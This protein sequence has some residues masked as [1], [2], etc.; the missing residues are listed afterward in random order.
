MGDTTRMI[1]FSS[2]YTWIWSRVY[3]ISFPG[4]QT[5]GLSMKL[6]IW[7][8]WVFGLLAAWTSQ[9]Q[10]SHELAPHR[11]S[12][13]LFFYLCLTPLCPTNC[14]LG[15]LSHSKLSFCPWKKNP[16]FSF[17]KFPS[18]LV[19]LP[20]ER[21]VSQLPAAACCYLLLPAATCCYLLL[22]TTCFVL[23]QVSA[24]KEMLIP[25]S[26]FS[27]GRQEF[28]KQGTCWHLSA[29]SGSKASPDCLGQLWS[30]PANQV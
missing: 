14:S 16:S 1:V 6:Y 29:S 25:C 5:F 4:S 26:S 19:R 12:Q 18:L 2:L 13:S 27:H 30:G 8:F 20:M 17:E 24:E 9:T 10:W 28:S 3:A 23:A 21:M 11:N 7:F 22:P 15:K